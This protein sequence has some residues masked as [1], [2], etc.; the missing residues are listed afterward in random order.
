MSTCADVGSVIE[1][2]MLVVQT[3]N[4]GFISEVSDYLVV[5]TGPGLVFHVGRIWEKNCACCAGPL[6]LKIFLLLLHSLTLLLVLQ[7]CRTFFK[8]S[9]YLHWWTVC[10]LLQVCLHAN[11]VLGVTV[12]NKCVQLHCVLCSVVCV[13]KLDFFFL[14]LWV[15]ICMWGLEHIHM[16]GKGWS[17]T[18]SNNFD[19]KNRTPESFRLFLG[20][21]YTWTYHTVLRNIKHLNLSDCFEAYH[22]PEPTRLFWGISLTWT[23]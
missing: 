22:T 15:H 23:Y 7:L 20:I 21:S 2:K 12:C 5:H 14:S 9:E 1:S 18:G 10:I 17:I 13:C 11:C 8:I 3:S 16:C 19:D 4:V 6:C